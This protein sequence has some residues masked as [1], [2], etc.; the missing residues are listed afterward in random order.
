MVSSTPTARSCILDA[1]PLRYLLLLAVHLAACG[2]DTFGLDTS[3]STTGSPS[4]TG[5]EPPGRES[6]GDDPIGSEPTGSEPTG[7]VG[8]TEMPVNP[9]STTGTEPIDTS[10]DAGSTASLESSSSTGVLCQDPQNQ[11]DGADCNDAC[12]CK[13]GKC[14]LIPVTGG[15]CGEC[16]EDSDCPNGG[17][18]VP[19]PVAQV[20]SACNMGEPGAGCMTDAVCNDPNNTSCGT[21]YDVPSIIKIRTCGECDG[22]E[23]SDDCTDPELPNCSPAYDL[24]NFGGRYACV[25]DNSKPN[26]EGCNPAED[27]YIPGELIGNRDCMS[28]FCGEADAQGLP[29]GICGECNVDA[30]CPM[31]MT[32]SEPDADLQ[33]GVLTGA[34]CQ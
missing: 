8:S 22:A 5:D 24:L 13:S 26:N 32:C 18:T 20:G 4:S 17:C 19:N 16:L 25:G 21:L 23:G 15:F 11:A 33:T 9:T 1:L 3:T 30:D 6:T 34:F 14:F 10:T 7:D 12:G 31:N 2:L 29:L 28:G 27:P